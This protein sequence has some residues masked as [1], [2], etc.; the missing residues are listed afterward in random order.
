MLKNK[1]LLIYGLLLL[2][3]I[4]LSLFLVVLHL[5]EYL[6]LTGVFFLVLCVLLAREISNH[7]ASDESRYEKQVNRIVKT[8]TPI[9]VNTNTFPNLKNKSILPIPQFDDLVNAQA[10]V[11]K[12]IYYV[13]GKNSTAFYLLNDEVF[14]IY[15]VKVH[16][17]EKCDL[18]LEIDSIES[19]DV[20]RVEDS[21][22]QTGEVANGDLGNTVVN[23]ENVVDSSE[24][25][26]SSSAENEVFVDEPVIES[27]TTISDGSLNVI[28]DA[29]SGHEESDEMNPTI[30]LDIES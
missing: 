21:V 1:K 27:S 2:N 12:P 13:K 9:L 3:M 16:E 20:I 23:M 19:S 8:Y 30:V 22:P 6:I 11:R 24:E 14:L 4:I 17:N 15:Y 10:E 5:F 25:V 29:Y 7:M 28:A 18:E 26:I